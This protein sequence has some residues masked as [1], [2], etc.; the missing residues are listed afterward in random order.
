MAKV[1]IYLHS[2]YLAVPKKKLTMWNTHC[3][4]IF[5]KT[6]KEGCIIKR[7]F[8]IKRRSNKEMYEKTFDKVLRKGAVGIGLYAPTEVTSVPVL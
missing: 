4:F 3:F 8:Q 2:P 1:I 5:L 6:K 7:S